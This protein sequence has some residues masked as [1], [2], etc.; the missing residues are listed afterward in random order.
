MFQTKAVM[1][2]P[3][4]QRRDPAILWE[5]G[6]IRKGYGGGSA[7]DGSVFQTK[8]VMAGPPRQRRD[9]AIL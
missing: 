1:A 6:V 5:P 3:P 2:G 4:R 7:Y 9:P 8:A